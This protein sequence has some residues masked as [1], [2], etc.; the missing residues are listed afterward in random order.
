MAADLTVV[1]RSIEIDEPADG[2]I[3]DVDTE[4]RSSVDDLLCGGIG[5]SGDESDVELLWA[6][7]GV[8]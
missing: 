1:E 2:G 5:D 4:Q 3:G 7:W 8:P 6:D